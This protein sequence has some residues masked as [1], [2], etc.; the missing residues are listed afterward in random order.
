MIII[1]ANGFKLSKKVEFI[2][3]LIKLGDLSFFVPI[4]FLIYVI[5]VRTI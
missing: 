5:K 3:K 2:E 4:Y 1:R